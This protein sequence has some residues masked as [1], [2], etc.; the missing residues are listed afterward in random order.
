MSPHSPRTVFIT[1]ASSGIGR[2]LAEEFGTRGDV[3]VA[4]ARRKK[5]LKE[6]ERSLRVKGEKCFP[7]VCDIGNERQVK[8]AV[9]S[10]FR[11]VRQIDILINNAGVTSFKNFLAMS[12]K[13][14]HQVI[15]TNLTGTFLVTREI[16]RRMLRRRRGLILNILSYAAQTTYTGSAAYSASKAGGAAMMK[17][18][19]EEVRHQH[20]RIVNIYPGAVLTPIWHERHRKN[21]GHRMMKPDDLAAFVYEISRQPDAFTV[22]EVVM[23]PEHGDLK[24]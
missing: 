21:Y 2:A 3:V 1:G 14:F 5:E 12:P 7:I 23:R 22:E 24:V 4:V 17:V 6:L 18:L 20:I 15:S 10:A 13:E 16:V 11:R 19:R 8:S 9:G